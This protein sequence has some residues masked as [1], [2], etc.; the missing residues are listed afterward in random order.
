VYIKVA[1]FV[2]NAGER[3]LIKYLSGNG[4]SLFINFSFMSI[5]DEH[6]IQNSECVLM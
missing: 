3:I 5:N 4:N 2:D 6:V 1:A